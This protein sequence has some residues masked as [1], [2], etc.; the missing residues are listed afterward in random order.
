M[1]KK[2]ILY[3]ILLFRDY[4]YFANLKGSKT[5]DKNFILNSINTSFSFLFILPLVSVSIFITRFILQ[6][7]REDKY[8][9]YLYNIIIFGFCYFFIDKIFNKKVKILNNYPVNE[10]RDKNYNLTLVYYILIGIAY[11]GICVIL[12]IH[13]MSKYN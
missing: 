10:T 2:I 1:L 5:I 4:I 12:P 6:I 11:I 3:I 9:T 8:S 13:I 7:K